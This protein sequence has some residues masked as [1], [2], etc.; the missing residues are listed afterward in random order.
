MLNYFLKIGRYLWT[1]LYSIITINIALLELLFID[2]KYW[3]PVTSIDLWQQ[4]NIVYNIWGYNMRMSTINCTPVRKF[5]FWPL[6]TSSNF[7]WPLSWHSVTSIDLWEQ[8]NIVYAI[9]GYPMSISTKHCIPMSN[10]QFLPLMISSNFL[11]PLIWH[12]VTYW[13]LRSK[14][15]SL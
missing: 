1:T 10:F 2:L 9:W 8:N 6:L 11:L 13:P 12:P 3:P 5:Q 4:N 14:Q 7:L 15:N